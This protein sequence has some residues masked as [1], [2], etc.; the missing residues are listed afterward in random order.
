MCLRCRLFGYKKEDC[1]S[2]GISE[3]EKEKAFIASHYGED[4]VDYM[5]GIDNNTK[6]KDIS[7]TGE[8]IKTNNNIFK[9]LSIN[10]N[11]T[12]QSLKELST[13]IRYY[14][15]IKFNNDIESF[16]KLYNDLVKDV[17]FREIKFEYKI[18]L[19]AIKNFFKFMWSKIN[20]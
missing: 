8:F 14:N 11:L 15:S 3:Q 1:S 6:D 12:H 4:V 2:D 10:V 7:A 13:A 19:Y 9:N 16:N 20:G 5:Y 18:N 17:P